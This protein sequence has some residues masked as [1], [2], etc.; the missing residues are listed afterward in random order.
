MNVISPLLVVLMA[1]GLPLTVLSQSANA[2]LNEDYYH[3]IDR[4]EIKSGQLSP[5]FHTSWKAYPRQWIAQFADSIDTGM[6]LS[7]QDRFNLQYLR[8][9][10]WEWS[11]RDE[12]TSKKPVFNS[13]YKVKSDLFHVI[14][15]DLDLHVNPVLHLSVGSESADDANMFIN[16]RGVELRGMIDNKVGFYSFL[17]ENQLVNP[18]YV[19]QRRETNL[20]VPH[21]GFWKGYE[22]NG[23]DFFTARGYVSFNATEHINFQF[24]HDRFTV[25]NGHRSMI[26]SDFS[27][28]YLFLKLNAKVW[29]FNY[30]SLFTEMTADVFGSSGG[31][32]GSSRYPDKYM[33]LHHLSINIGKKV[34]VG[35]FEAVIF[36]NDD[37][38]SN[39][40]GFELRYLN[41]VIFYRAVEQQNGSPDNVLLGTDVKW[42]VT[43][44]FS[45]YGQLVFDEFLLD[46]LRE[47]TGWWGNKWAVQ[48]GGEYIDAFGIKNLDLQGEVNV[49][50]PYTYTHNTPLGSYSNYRQPLA[51][52]LGANFREFVGIAR[53]QPLDRLNV[54]AK[55]VYANYGA[56]T[57]D[58]NWGANI[59]LN[60]ETREMDFGNEIAQGVENDLLFGDV[61]VSYQWRHN[62]F[63]DLKHIY[64]RLDSA[65]PGL[66]EETNFTSLVLRWNIPQRLHEF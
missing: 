41:P 1:V 12:N 14:T 36:N 48:M 17:A 40:G 31:L 30:T 60:S 64:R 7:R 43:K 37:S 54:T 39:N 16:S 5:F 50:R 38:V 23:V 56:D 18:L 65:L 9:D 4:Y 51:H 35:L 62:F 25:G 20:V 57:T 22:E 34:N 15:K 29:K 44:G 52:P 55:L 66:S 3:L 10:N 61:T 59:L 24:G 53:Y 19:R 42:L 45:L 27:P 47:G 13:L 49:S 63:I 32:S 8:N 2:P 33:A 21:E 6:T 11:G 46:N 58:S 26:L 28:A